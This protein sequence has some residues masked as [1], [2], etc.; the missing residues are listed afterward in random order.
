MSTL[1][2]SPS[3]A[4]S[5]RAPGL[6]HFA[7]QRRSSNK[8]P[9]HPQSASPALYQHPSATKPPPTCAPPQPPTTDARPQYVDAG[10]QYTPDGLPPTD[11]RNTTS[12][13]SPIAKI[14]IGS[15]PPASMISKTES[16]KAGNAVPVTPQ[17]RELPAKRDNGPV[18]HQLPERPATVEEPAPPASV[19]STVSKRAKTSSDNVKTMPWKYETC[20]PKDLGVLIANMLMELIRLNDNIPLRDGKLTRFHSRSVN[21]SIRSIVPQADRSSIELLRAFHATTTSKD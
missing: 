8:S 9:L 4:G 16:P 11:R 12:E 7:V 20:N 3:P 6:S 13:G 14:R 2:T 15:S 1:T 21:T 18:T 5:P 19:T 17:P 10:T